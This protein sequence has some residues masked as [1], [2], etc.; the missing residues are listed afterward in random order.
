MEQIAMNLESIVS[1][2]IH[3][4]IGIARVGN[5]PRPDDYFVGVEVPY[6]VAPPAGGYRDQQG[7]LKRQG[8]R[9]PI[10]GFDSDG[11]VVAELTDNI[12]LIEWHVHVANKKAAWYN[13]DAA[14]DIPE[15]KGTKVPRRNAHI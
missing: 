4:A 13:F 14:L 15:A 5:A 7:R 12:A 9:F 8:A 2:R 6:P 3:P 11:N 10:Y 1:A